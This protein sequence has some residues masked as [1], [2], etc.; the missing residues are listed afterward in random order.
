LNG[1][2]E[3]GLWYSWVSSC[4][5]AAHQDFDPHHLQGGDADRVYLHR[6]AQQRS[7]WKDQDGLL[8]LSAWGGEIGKD[9]PAK[10]SKLG[11]GGSH[12]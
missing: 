12:L 8:D 1:L 11:A 6:L 2:T 3:G 5:L 7:P 9:G 4:K 10:V